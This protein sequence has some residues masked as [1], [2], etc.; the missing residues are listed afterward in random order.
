MAGPSGPPGGA[1]LERLLL[2]A[3]LLHDE[4]GLAAW[5]EIRVALGGRSLPASTTAIFGALLENLK[6][7]GVEGDELRALELVQQQVWAHNSGLFAATGSQIERLEQAGIAT[8]L[9]KGAALVAAGRQRLGFRF[10][11]DVDV[12]VPSAQ[13]EDAVR[14][15]LGGELRPFG[16]E[17]VGYLLSAWPRYHTGLTLVGEHGHQV[18]L[19]WH[20][21]RL[22]RQEGADDE[23]WAAAQDATLRGVATR[24][25]CPADAL[26]HAILHGVMARGAADFRWV[27][28]A[29][30][31][32]R[33]VGEGLDWDRLVE[34]A[35]ARRVTVAVRWALSYMRTEVDAA[36]GQPVLRSLRSPGPHLLERVEFTAWRTAPTAWRRRERVVFYYGQCARREL[37]LRR[38]AGLFAQLA[39]ARRGFGI[40]GPRDLAS[41][42]AGGTP[43]PGR[44]IAREAAAVYG[45]QTARGGLKVGLGETVQL[46]VG[47]PVE[48]LFRYGAWDGQEGGVWLAGREAELALAP[49]A[50]VDG[51][52]ILSL[53]LSHELAEQV[54]DTRLEVRAQGAR[55]RRFEVRGGD[56]GLADARVVIPAA[57]ATAGTP[58]ALELRFQKSISPARLGLSDD[59]RDLSLFLRAITLSAPPRVAV[60]ASLDFGRG[61]AGE[62][63]LA[64]GW[65]A[66]ENDGRWSDGPRAGLVLRVGLTPRE[67]TLALELVADAYLGSPPRARVLEI[68][69]CGRRLARVEYSAADAGAPALRTVLVPAALLDGHD[70]LGLELRMRPIGSP[71]SQRVGADRRLLGIFLR[72][73]RLA[74]A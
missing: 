22:S 67:G 5:E 6:P 35:R 37:P 19:H 16:R 1:Q 70:E 30:V 63:A 68:H 69:A 24:V 12:L 43:G 42:T 39:V 4:R 32:M 20:L 72:E 15:L 21:L 10:M 65:S 62:A 36:V 25:L 31:I 29:S 61:G 57:L 51:S 34:Q 23:F 53:S 13:R 2:R 66:A 56:P 44:P 47:A 54:G 59:D 11:S 27:L 14:L 48:R 58:L 41:L 38:R 28:D 45:E 3:A 74:R 64:G 46:G 33:S 71:Q 55:L 17:S 60:P 50:P 40:R 73:I 9:L 49:T 8:L 26:L 7:L 52:L 18:D